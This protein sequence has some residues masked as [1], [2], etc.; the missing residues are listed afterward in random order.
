M[1]WL[2]FLAL[3][4]AALLLLATPV[5]RRPG[6]GSE[7]GRLA[8]YRDQLREVEREA[9]AGRLAPTEATAA[10]LEIQRRMLAVDRQQ[11]SE[12]G[13][14]GRR[15]VLVPVACLV[16][17]GPLG[18]Y[19]SL[20]TP[21]MPDIPLSSRAEETGELRELDQAIAALRERLARDWEDAGA[22]AKLAQ[23]LALR[24]QGEEALERLAEARRHLPLRSD[25]ASL[26][27]D[28]LTRQADGLVTAQAKLSFEDALKNDPSDARARYNL[29]LAREQ[30][31]DPT[32]ALSDLETLGRSAPAG[33]SWYPRVAE[34]ARALATSLG[35]DPAS[36][37]IAPRGPD[38]AGMAGMATLSDEQRSAAIKGMVD[39]LSA[40]LENDPNDI[41]GWLRLARAR[42]VLGDGLG[43]TQA[44][45]AAAERAPGRV[46]VQLA[47]ARALLP[48]Q[49]GNAP[50]TPQ[51][52]EI[53][54][55]VLA[56]DPDQPEALWF[57]GV[58]ALESGAPEKARTLWQKLKEFL[59][60]EA[61]EAKTID[62]A[63]LSLPRK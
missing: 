36:L 20:G 63:L 5:F 26:Q 19:L 8:V 53:Y 6:K 45:A 52:I 55:R 46:D 21:G 51:A 57:G 1:V 24:G 50:L 29:A 44:L 54:G 33:A 31:G 13:W 62:R 61:P 10:K 59:P 60:T 12:A 41:D 35:R 9:A 37:D 48:A 28:L 49:M 34:K 18:V 22:M 38:A 14:S 17:A 58:A 40:R 3:A 23:A 30:S 56:L 39:N 15:A 4:A 7:D 2:G 42:G 27:G 11:R 25:L 47:Y 43:A 32:G 16:L